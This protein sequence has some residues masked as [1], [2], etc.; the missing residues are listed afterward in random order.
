LVIEKLSGES[1]A[2]YFAH[3]I[4]ES[5]HSGFATMAAIVP[6]M[7]GYSREASTLRHR[8]QHVVIIV[9]ANEEDSPVRDIA[10]AM[11][12]HLVGD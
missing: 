3:H 4:S 2:A 10:D 12:K 9:L 6:Q 8:D 5:T 1:Y 11:A 7:S